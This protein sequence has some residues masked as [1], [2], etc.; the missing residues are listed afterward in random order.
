M[1]PCPHRPLE[2]D[3]TSSPGTPRPPSRWTTLWLPW[4]FPKIK[5][6]ENQE[7]FHQ[8][9]DFQK[10]QDY[11]A[12]ISA[13]LSWPLQNRA[14]VP[15]VPRPHSSPLH[16]IISHVQHVTHD[17]MVCLRVEICLG[18]YPYCPGHCMCV[19]GSHLIIFYWA[20]TM[21]QAQC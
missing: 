10:T 17:M 16:P 13:W 21:C 8:N 1:E 6:V 2:A 14:R 20:P 12:R 9:W 5:L 15:Q 3:C 18:L 19:Y 7:L 4:C 11:W